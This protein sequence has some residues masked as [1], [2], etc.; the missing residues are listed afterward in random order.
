MAMIHMLQYVGMFFSTL[1]K[2]EILETCRL[3]M[4]AK[5][6]KMIVHL[7]SGNNDF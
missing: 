3:G 7:M 4:F 5:S 6:S 1:Y 2:Y